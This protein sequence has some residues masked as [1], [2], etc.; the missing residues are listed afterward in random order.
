MKRI[1]FILA[2]AF[3]FLLICSCGGNEGIDTTD[4]ESL[5]NEKITLRVEYIAGEGGSIDGRAKQSVEVTKGKEVSFNRVTAVAN[6]GYYFVKWSDGLDSSVRIDTLGESKSFTAIFEK[7]IE[8]KYEASDGGKV[9]GNKTQY[10]KPNEE[11]SQIT[12]VASNGYKFVGWSDG[13]KEVERTD[14]ATESCEYIAIFEKIQ[15]ATVSYKCDD[16]GKIEGEATQMLEK[17]T[18]SK[19]IIAVPS[20]EGYY[21]VRWDDGVLTSQRS[22]IVTEDKT[23]TAIFSNQITIRYEATEGGYI[24]GNKEQTMAYG[25]YSTSVSAI[26]NEGYEFVGWDDGYQLDLRNDQARASVTYKAIFKIPY[27]VEFKCDTERGTILGITSQKVYRGEKSRVVT[28]IPNEGYTFVCWSD[29]S[30]NPEISVTALENTQVYAHFSFASTGLPVISIDTETGNDVTS[31]TEYIGCTVSLYDTE[32]NEHFVEQVARIRGRGNSTWERFPKKPYKIKFDTKQDFFDNG[33]AKT[34]VLLADYRDYSL[35]RNMLA[36]EV[37]EELSEL[38]ATPDCQSVEVYLNGKYH[39]VYLLCEQIEVNDHRV[40]VSENLTTTESSFLVEMDGWTDDVQVYVP[41][42]LNS[43]RR[44]SVKF[45]DSEEITDEQKKYIENYLKSCISA[46][47]GSDYSLVTDLIDVKSFAQA[48]IIFELFKNPDTNYSS[49][50]F[51]KDIDGKLICGPLWDF[52][53]SVGNVS[54]KGNGVFESTETLW[55]KAEC[56][57]FK[58]LLNFK[59]FADLVGEELTEYAP[60]IRATIERK[61]EYVYAHSDAYKKNFEKWDI[62]GKQ[63][64]SNPE[65]LVEIT[66]WEEHVE[67][68]RSYL[69]KSLQYLEYYYCDKEN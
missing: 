36:Y 48:Y 26:T 64:W 23:V 15:Y 27:T 22:D 41:D 50:Y 47:Q 6:E 69:E 56:P 65:Y 17:G 30:Q 42:N 2:I 44:Y 63:T 19:Q 52:D 14:I 3:C 61:L 32:N 13:K 54:H 46:I 38:K 24:V 45:P 35:I 16:G 57:W 12:A 66:T 34:W 1:Y 8:I 9:Y 33:K 29:G 25:S 18:E 31:K 51:Y 39:G 43:G 53:M 37:G 55:S 4:T 62:L 59:E 20:R 21:F 10:L 40:E 5:N 68:V 7:C 49:L 28:A 11:T 60:I 67:Y 58:G